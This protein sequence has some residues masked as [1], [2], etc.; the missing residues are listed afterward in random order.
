MSVGVG[1]VLASDWQ[2]EMGSH[3]SRDVTCKQPARCSVS[4]PLTLSPSCMDHKHISHLPEQSWVCFESSR[5]CNTGFLNITNMIW[6]KNTALPGR[7]V[8]DFQCEILFC[9][10]KLPSI[11]CFCQNLCLG[12]F[13]QWACCHF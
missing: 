11:Y 7:R 2:G 9:G 8:H 6:M 10:R 3:S 13:F 5:S 12:D 4:C 1:L